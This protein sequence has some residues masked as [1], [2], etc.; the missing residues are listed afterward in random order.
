VK[1]LVG[2]QLPPALARFLVSRGT[3]CQ[4]VLD[5]NLAEATDA[6]IWE[7][8]CQNECVVISKDEGFLYLA[9]A[10]PGKARLI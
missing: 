10:R 2:S 9:N 8:A 6:E 7:Y 3:D 4:H 1:F 5:I